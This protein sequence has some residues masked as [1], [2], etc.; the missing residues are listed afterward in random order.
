MS[1]VV[2]LSDLDAERK[3]PLD[4]TRAVLRS[5][6]RD[7]VVEPEAVNQA[8]HRIF[9]YPSAHSMRAEAGKTPMPAMGTISRV[10]IHLR[11]TKNL[12]DFA[13]IPFL[14]AFRAVGKA[15]LRLLDIDRQ[16]AEARVEASIA[17]AD[18]SHPGERIMVDECH[19]LHPESGSSTPRIGKLIAAGA[20]AYRQ[21]VRNDG[22]AFNWSFL[23]KVC[24]AI[25][26]TAGR[27]LAGDPLVAHC[28]TPEEAIDH[29]VQNVVVP[30][31]WVPIEDLVSDGLEIPHHEVVALYTKDGVYIG[32]VIHHPGLHAVITR[33][34]YTDE[35]LAAGKVS[36]FKGRHE[37]NLGLG[38]IWSGSGFFARTSDVHCDEP[39]YFSRT[40]VASGLRVKDFLDKPTADPVALELW[41]GLRCG[42]SGHRWAIDG[43]RSFVRKGDRDL[44]QAS[45]A[46]TNTWPT[47]NDF[48]LLF[49]L[50]QNAS[51]VPAPDSWSERFREALLLPPE[52]IELQKRVTQ[53][54]QRDVAEARQILEDPDEVQALIHLLLDS[55][56]IEQ[57]ERTAQQLEASYF[58]VAAGTSESDMEN[59]R[60]RLVAERKRDDEFLPRAVEATLKNYPYLADFGQTTVWYIT[61]EAWHALSDFEDTDLLFEVALLVELVVLASAGASR[62][63]TLRLRFQPSIMA[64]G[65]WAEGQASLE[66]V[67]DLASEFSEYQYKADALES[68]VAAVGIA[69]TEEIDSRERAL[70]LGVRYAGERVTV[71]PSGRVKNRKIHIEKK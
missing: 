13:Q 38:S 3:R 44:Y 12:R 61:R 6:T 64:V 9:G 48:P 33:I 10:D 71:R 50:E 29:Y 8:A 67:Q 62:K 24:V 32:R 22:S 56:G 43:K 66:D 40:A 68:R 30:E 28:S 15:K 70:E 52:M 23:M 27:I 5:L 35:E 20:P 18:T 47:L 65:R 14:P 60:Q 58:E 37:Q 7:G 45:Y 25:D 42:S 57:I 55:I 21:I 46:P 51:H 11:L 36:F 4:I 49:P 63:A 53:K 17:A 39:V 19:P 69:V 2:I 34:F 16:T 41:P 31:A 59:E 26:K 54:I 1:L